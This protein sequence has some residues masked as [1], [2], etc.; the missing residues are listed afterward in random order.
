MR[1]VH[2][3][4]S[5]S[6]LMVFL[7]SP[8]VL[9]AISTQSGYGGSFATSIVEP[10]HSF[11]L[12]KITFESDVPLS[13]EE[14]LYL[15]DL[16]TG[17][18]VTKKKI[19]RAYKQLTLKRRF[20]AIDINWSDYDTGKHLHF[21]FFGNWI[22]QKLDFNG[23]MFGKQKYTALYTQ[24][25]GDTFDSA[26]H[27]ESIKA[28]KNALRNEG[29]FNCK[30]RD[31]L[32]YSKKR[33]SIDIKI[34]ASRKKCFHITDINFELMGTEHL[35]NKENKENKA[36][37]KNI[38][39]LNNLLHEKY[40]KPLLNTYYTKKKIDKQIKKI[41]DLFK[42]Q[43]FFNSRIT[44]ARTIDHNNTT[45]KLVIKIQLG[46]RKIIKFEG[47]TLFT[48]ETI[49]SEF[50]GEDQPDWLF[51]PDIITEQILHEYYKKGFW[52]TSINYKKYGSVGF[53]FR[54]K[55]GS[56]VIINGVE[57]TQAS[58]GL[59]ESTTFFWDELLKHR[60]FDQAIL[61]T[62]ITKLK[63][64]YLSHGFWDFRIIEQRFMR[65]K[66]TGLY[67][68]RLTI[69]K[70][71]QRFW[72]GFEIERFK[73]LE[74]EA[75]F[76][77]YSL[78]NTE[79]LAPFD[80]HWLQEQRVFLMSHFQKNGYW[81]VDV[82]PELLIFPVESPNKPAAIK[83]VVRWKVTLGKR[84][85]FGKVV[86][87]GNTKLPFKRI[88]KELR[89]KKGD[90]WS[91]DKLDL[92]RKKLKRL[93]LFKSIQLQP[94]QLASRK[95]QKP[96]ILTLIDD[97]P[98]EVRL[99]AGYFLTSKNFMFKQ[100]STPKVG[101]SV[102]MKNPTNRA[103][104]LALNVD[105]TRFDKTLTFAYQQ[106]SPFN[107]TSAMGQIK[108]FANK[109]VQPMQIDLCGSAYEAA[110]YGFLFGLSDEY[111]EDYH[112]AFNIGN[113]WFKTTRVRGNLKLDPALINKSVPYFF[114]E[115]TLI[116]DKLDDRVNT[117][118]GTLGFYSLKTMLPENRLGEAT[119]RLM[120][121]QS[122]FYPVYNDIVL[123]ARIRFGYYFKRKFNHIMPSERFYLGGPYSVRGYE[124]DALPPLGKS[125]KIENCQEKVI[126]TIQ[127]GSSMINGN[128]ELRFPL[129][130]SF[131]MVLFQ[132][133]GI[134]SQTGLAGFKGPWFPTS[135]F[136]LR[137][138][139]PIGAFRFDIGWKWKDHK[140]RESSRD[141]SY[142][143]YL[144]LGEAF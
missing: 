90:T 8:F 10:E 73:E 100:Q 78:L 2:K 85:K 124:K 16:K 106:P 71:K 61:E 82:Q 33:K 51:S 58:T 122:A 128:L 88:V 45:V 119:A 59:P 47:N 11:L 19:D 80:I 55:E 54:I 40:K 69:A 131:G 3:K 64:F 65:N 127:G 116:I 93:D 66:K 18:F 99:R 31:E 17:N 76:K 113:E 108:G 25:P 4:I 6:F 22:V 38:A 92:T 20:L 23:I 105:W 142:A 133:I 21:K 118:K 107:L 130:K 57:V 77:K 138:K 53:L 72:G 120:L 79:Q 50:L 5:V 112:W 141:C 9:T 41:R 98:V 15:T 29:Y 27:E 96:V 132:D 26:V 43:G 84:V 32:I 125:I 46:K 137:Y 109:Y 28:I 75:F 104:K 39:S 52:H 140:S 143:W 24:Q 111:K 134:L 34:T 13:E 74:T 129:Y 101:A 121:D 117:K 42:R 62:C 30:V 91:R 86:V 49:K 60:T 36:L 56:P 126:Y 67:T 12:S 37:E 135:G 87:R 94:H 114:V 123:A 95:S 44:M 68:I 35:Q 81:Y 102:V 144:T 115:P 89:F 97:D 110:Q 136:G 139:T 14:F 48:E 83:I 103:D 1:N 7:I 63:N 70:G